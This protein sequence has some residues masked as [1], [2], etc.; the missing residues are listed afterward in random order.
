MAWAIEITPIGVPHEKPKYLRPYF[1]GRF[2]VGL[3]PPTQY[4]GY[5]T[6]VFNTRRQAESIAQDYR[7]FTRRGERKDCVLYKRVRVVSVTVTV[8]A[9]AREGG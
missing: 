7:R 4:S 3:E 1:V 2:C 8:K 5:R 9:T 6:A